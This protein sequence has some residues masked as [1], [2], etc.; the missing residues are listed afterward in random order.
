MELLVTRVKRDRQDRLVL[1]EK[2]GLREK[3]E[4]VVTWGSQGQWV[5]RVR[6]E[7][8]VWMPLMEILGL[9]EHLE[10]RA[11]KV[12]LDRVDHQDKPG[13]KVKRGKM[14]LSRD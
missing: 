4:L 7:H 5:P 11:L 3:R 8:L 13:P 10:T 9:L 12:H 6:K 1:L 2:M 14:K